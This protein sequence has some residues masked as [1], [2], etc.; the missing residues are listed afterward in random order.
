M[1]KHA[2]SVDSTVGADGRTSKKSRRIVCVCGGQRAVSR[3]AMVLNESRYVL[4]HDMFLS[5]S[6]DLD[7][8]RAPRCVCF[9]NTIC[10]TMCFCYEMFHDMFV[11]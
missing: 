8:N 4:F 6:P 3:Y 10:F 1:P 9:H 5:I 7:G 2:N 11:Y